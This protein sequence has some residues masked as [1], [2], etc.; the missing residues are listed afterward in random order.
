MTAVL[1]VYGATTWATWVAGPLSM[2]LQLAACLALA[3][4]VS[5]RGRRTMIV[6][7]FVGCAAAVLPVVGLLGMTAAAVVVGPPR[8]PA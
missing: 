6:W 4:V 7:L 8:A 5:H 3:I 1:A 2:A